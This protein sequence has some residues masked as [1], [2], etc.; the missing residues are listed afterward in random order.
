MPSRLNKLVRKIPGVLFLIYFT[1]LLYRLFFFAYSEYFRFSVEDLRF[2]LIPFKTILTY[3]SWVN[4]DNIDV[5]FYNLFGNVLAFMPM[6]FLL[7]LVFTKLKSAKAIMI[8]IFITSS[9]LEGIQLISK[10]GTADIDDVILNT[11]GGFLGYLLLMKSR[12]LLRKSVRLE[13]D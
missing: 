10:L 3:I 8:T 2:N 1:Y 6:G 9:V 12:R 7:P 11:L 5:W 4:D 13:E